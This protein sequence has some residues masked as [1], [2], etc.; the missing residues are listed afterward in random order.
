MT[1]LS[2][3]ENTPNQSSIWADAIVHDGDNVLR[4]LSPWSPTI[5]RYLDHLHRHGITQVPRCVGIEGDQER[6]T[7]V[8]GETFNY[9]LTGDI[10]HLDALTS[11]GA[12]LRRIHDASVSFLSA[13]FLTTGVDERI[14]M[15]PPREP[16]EVICH[17]DFA[18]YNVALQQGQVVGVFDF[19]TAHPAPR[20]WD[21]AYAIYC[22]APFKTHEADRLGTLDDQIL[23]AKAFCDSYG[24]TQAQRAAL[25]AAMVER[26]TALVDFMHTEANSGNV[27]FA[28]NIVD[29]HHLAYVADIAYIQRHAVAITQGILMTS[30]HE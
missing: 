6:L 22:W 10:A 11:A 7:F 16:A 5:H 19:D 24:V 9:P 30:D 21:L 26:L 20:L 27:Q 8:A 12:L 14:W 17:G 23:R 28:A 29:G 13:P 15:L 1:R 2:D 18:P 25:A 3:S 4:P